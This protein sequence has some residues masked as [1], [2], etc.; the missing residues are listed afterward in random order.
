ML[1]IDFSS[2]LDSVDFGYPTKYGFTALDRDFLI[3]VTDCDT[4]EDRVMSARQLYRFLGTY[5][6]E[7]YDHI[8][9]RLFCLKSLPPVVTRKLRKLRVIIRFIYR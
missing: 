4:L 3:V 6:F 2:D 1:L 5:S 9:G 8:V 7:L